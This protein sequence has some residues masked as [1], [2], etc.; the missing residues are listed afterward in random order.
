MTFKKLDEGEIELKVE[1][2]EKDPSVYL[3]ASHLNIKDGETTV[4]PTFSYC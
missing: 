2:P 1:V 4:S 3:S